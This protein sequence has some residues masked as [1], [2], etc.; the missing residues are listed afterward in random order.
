MTTTVPAYI[1]KQSRIIV[2]SQIATVK[3]RIPVLSHIRNMNIANTVL[4]LLMHKATIALNPVTIAGRY[5]A[6]QCLDDHNPCLLRV[7][8]FDGQLNLIASLV[9][10]Q[11][12]RATL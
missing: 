5:F 11:F 10:K 6:T 9:Y 12:L 3:F 8:I 7:A 4:R 2:F 1:Y